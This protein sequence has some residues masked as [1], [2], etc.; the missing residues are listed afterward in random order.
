MKLKEDQEK[1]AAEEARLK[2]EKE[3]VCVLSWLGYFWFYPQI[4][5]HTTCHTQQLKEEQER[6]AAEEAR[7]K[8]EQQKVSFSVNSLLNAYHHSHV[9]P[10]F[11]TKA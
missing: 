8:A 2:A 3:K 5:S 7:I 10:S 11:N 4:Y 1:K 9:L 6:K